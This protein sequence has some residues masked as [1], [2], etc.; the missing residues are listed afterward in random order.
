MLDLNLLLMF[1][2]IKC[3]L[4]SSIFLEKLAILGIN[5][6]LTVELKIKISWKVKISNKIGNFPAIG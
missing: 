3:L 4:F 2:R 5:V 6:R 1:N